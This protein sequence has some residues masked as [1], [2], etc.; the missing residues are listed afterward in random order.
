MCV[1]GVCIYIY[2]YIYIV[3]RV[4][5]PQVHDVAWY[6]LPAKGLVLHGTFGGEKGVT[7]SPGECLLAGAYVLTGK[8]VPFVASG[9]T[10]QVIRSV[11]IYM[12][13]LYIC[14]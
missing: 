4:N 7:A 5:P 3:Y 14:M 10:H 6:V 11:C 2:T 9:E 13:N 1:C 8:Y 12:Y